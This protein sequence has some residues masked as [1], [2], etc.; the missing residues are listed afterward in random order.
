LS[1]NALSTSASGVGRFP[2]KYVSSAVSSGGKNQIQKDPSKAVQN[3]GPLYLAQITK[4]KNVVPKVIGAVTAPIPTNTPSL[5]KENKGKDLSVALVPNVSSSA[6]SSVWGVTPAQGVKPIPTS[7]PSTNP[8]MSLSKPAPWAKPSKGQEDPAAVDTAAPTEGKTSWAEDDDIDEGVNDNAKRPLQSQYENLEDNTFSYT[9]GSISAAEETAMVDK[10]FSGGPIDDQSRGNRYQPEWGRNSH[11]NNNRFPRFQQ[12]DEFPHNKGYRRQYSNRPDEQPQEFEGRRPRFNSGDATFTGG[13]TSYNNQPQQQQFGR[14]SYNNNHFGG[15]GGGFQ[16]G[17]DRGGHGN[18]Y[19]HH[20]YNNHALDFQSGGVPPSAGRFNQ[21]PPSQAS[22][23]VG[24]GSTLTPEEIEQ[25]ESI[26]K[27]RMEVALLDL[28]KQKLQQQ[29]LHEEVQRHED[30]QPYRGFHHYQQ[31]PPNMQFDQ[32]QS[33]HFPPQYQNVNPYGMP[34]KAGMNSDYFE[35]KS[36]SLSPNYP[37]VIRGNASATSKA[38]PIVPSTAIVPT[39][40]KAD[41]EVVWERAKKPEPEV[42]TTA[43]RTLSVKDGKEDRSAV[44]D[45]DNTKPATSETQEPI[46]NQS[47]PPDVSPPNMLVVPGKIDSANTQRSGHPVAVDAIKEV[48]RQS[49]LRSYSS[50]FTAAPPSK[51]TSGPSSN[52]NNSDIGDLKNKF[53]NSAQSPHSQI[54]LFNQNSGYLMPP[55]PHSAATHS[56]GSSD[57]NFNSQDQHQ[58]IPKKKMLFDPKSNQMVE[59]SLS[60][61]ADLHNKPYAGGPNTSNKSNPPYVK[62]NHTDSTNSSGPVSINSGRSPFLKRKAHEEPEGKWERVA[63]LPAVVVPVK[64]ESDEVASSQAN[65][66][67]FEVIQKEDEKAADLEVSEKPLPATVTH[68]V[69]S[70]PQRPVRDESQRTPYDTSKTYVQPRSAPEQSAR[71]LEMAERREARTKE[72][73]ARGPRTKGHLYR[74]NEAGEFERVFS[75]AELV[76][77]EQQPSK[78]DSDDVEDEAVTVEEPQVDDTIAASQVSVASSVP[79]KVAAEAW[80]APQSTL[81]LMSRGTSAVAESD[82]ATKEP[83]AIEAAVVHRQHHKQQAEERK[84]QKYLNKKRFK[85]DNEAQPAVAPSSNVLAFQSL[86]GI[87]SAFAAGLGLTDSTSSNNNAMATP[88]RL[89][90]GGLWVQPQQNPNAEL[91]KSLTRTS[92]GL[93]DSSGAGGSGYSSSLGGLGGGLGGILQTSS[94]LDANQ[95]NWSFHSSVQ[96]DMFSS[97]AYNTSAANTINPITITNT[98]SKQDA[99]SFSPFGGLSSAALHTS[100]DSADYPIVATDSANNANASTRNP[101]RRGRTR[102]TGEANFVRSTLSRNE[103]GGGNRGRPKGPRRPR[104]EAGETKEVAE[105]AAVGGEPAVAVERVSQGR[106]GGRG[107]GGGGVRGPG[108]VPGGRRHRE[109][110]PPTENNHRPRGSNNHNNHQNNTKNTSNNDNVRESSNDL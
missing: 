72:R 91:D 9:A 69:L 14:H 26:E 40:S 74:Y 19:R 110:P 46:L 42:K 84:T 55:F 50:F 61:S 29:Q 104:G 82:L 43:R 15:G 57:D 93:N 34:P 63:P 76:E 96:E 53:G 79:A 59:P 107:R 70:R 108:R 62:K 39:V 54:Q 85:H 51:P 3:G 83:P 37:A 109:G 5:L 73:L 60:T 94:L 102:P 6:S 23:E 77:L 67:G 10:K 52:N 11:D 56:F 66:G 25:Q 100:L 71:Q 36:K 7:T 22:H 106:G 38:G 98:S 44:A 17:F 87:A 65:E 24:G 16:H 18:N 64:Q 33:R 97:A 41:Q 28:K 88:S 58:N 68:S 86:D 90:A 8:Q 89:T 75:A 103:G 13:F 95:A 99:A 2:N 101:A 32:Q 48:Q 45:I 105:P 78:V 1:T 21:P 12:Q 81:R 47:L 27:A 35:P 31:A 20:N 4:S 92:V 30:Q 49:A 80:L